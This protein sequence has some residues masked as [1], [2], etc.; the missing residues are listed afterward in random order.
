[1]TPLHLAGRT[2]VLSVVALASLGQP[3]LLSFVQ[4]TQGVL[5]CSWLPG[6]AWSSPPQSKRQ[7]Q[8]FGASRVRLPGGASGKEP[9]YQCRRHKRHGFDPWV[10]KIPWRRT[11]QLTPVFSPRGSCG[12][13]GL[14]DYSP[15]GHKESYTTE[16]SEHA[17]WVLV[18]RVSQVVVGNTETTV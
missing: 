5:L 16:A 18:C 1:M 14:A 15:W 11:W 7:D 17:V 2:D 9:A 13:R 12:Q 6:S 4:G 3:V 10:R 8:G